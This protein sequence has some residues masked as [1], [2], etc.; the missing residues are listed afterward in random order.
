M[1]QIIDFIEIF[2]LIT[3]ILSYLIVSVV[4]CL[5]GFMEGYRTGKKTE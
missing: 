5:I 4:F 3:I 1:N 2:D